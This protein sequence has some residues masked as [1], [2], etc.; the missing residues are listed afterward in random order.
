VGG[1]V[2]F[3]VL[4][5]VPERNTVLL[6]WDANLKPSLLIEQPPYLML[7]QSSFR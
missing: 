7:S 6:E 1:Q 4:R 2:I 3:E 5:G